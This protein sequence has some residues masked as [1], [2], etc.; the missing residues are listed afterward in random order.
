MSNSRSPNDNR[1]SS[2]PTVE[3]DAIPDAVVVIDTQTEHVVGTN[4]RAEGL[5]G[6]S[7]SEMCGQHYLQY[8]A[9]SQAQ[10]AKKLFD[11]PPVDGSIDEFPDGS[12]LRIQRQSGELVPV[13]LNVSILPDEELVL[14]VF[15]DVSRRRDTE[16]QLTEVSSKF[17]TIFEQCNDAIVILDPDGDAIHEV[18]QQACAM[19]GYSREKLLRMSPRDL[20]PEELAELRSFLDSVIESNEGWTD[21]L[22]CR[23]KDGVKLETEISASLVELEGNDYVLAIIRDVSAQVR[24]KETLERQ[25]E[26]LE[27]LNRVVRHDIRNYMQVILSQLPL[28]ED[29]LDRSVQEAYHAVYTAAESTV[30]LTETVRTLVEDVVAGA[31]ALQPVQLKEL[32]RREVHDVSQRYDHAEIVLD[33]PIPDVRV[34]ANEMLGSVVHNLLTNA[35][36]HNDSSNPTVELA[37]E[38]HS[39]TVTLSVAD[40]GPGIP[41]TK[42]GQMF[43]KETRGL[44]SSGTGLGL[45]L[46]EALVDQYG[47]SVWVEDNE[48]HG[49]V[50]TVELHV[51]NPQE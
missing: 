2:V 48:P 37:V 30:E 43:E 41:D 15:R 8:H 20:H 10:Q 13:E 16:R 24:R 19:L 49:A 17:Q 29:Q 7:N 36:T 35:I 11:D 34:V 50:F 4:G 3:L 28:L 21:S 1:D 31:E 5:F 39:E 22:T 14:G 26:Q 38:A 46:V 9:P 27:V 51:A 45:Y 23:R 33:D 18:N 47:G 32:L 42:K 6:Y 40:N 25:R 44:D 12:P